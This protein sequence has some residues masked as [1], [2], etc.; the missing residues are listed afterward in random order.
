MFDVQYSD[1]PKKTVRPAT[2]AELYYSPMKR[3]SASR[4]GYDGN[5]YLVT[6]LGGNSTFEV[7]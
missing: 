6:S 7:E 5:I 4:Q 3:M 1:A 2:L